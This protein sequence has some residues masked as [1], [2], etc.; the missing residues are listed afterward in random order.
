MIHLKQFENTEDQ[1]Y[2]KYVVIDFG[3]TGGEQFYILKTISNKNP[4][5]INYDVYYYY[6]KDLSEIV[7]Y[8]DNNGKLNTRNLLIIFQTDSEDDAKNELLMLNNVSKYN[9]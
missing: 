7:Q 4:E 3:D 6:E 9:L 5:F 1:I 2:K 8:N